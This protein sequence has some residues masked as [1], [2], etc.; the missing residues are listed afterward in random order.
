MPR[1][2]CVATLGALPDAPEKLVV[3]GRPS[4]KHADRVE[5]AVEDSANAKPNHQ[6]LLEV[7]QGLT[8]KNQDLWKAFAGSISFPELKQQQFTATASALGLSLSQVQTLLAIV[9]PVSACPSRAK[10]GRWLATWSARAG[11]L[12]RVLDRQ[13]QKLVVCMWRKMESL[14]EK[15]EAADREVARCRR[16]WVVASKACR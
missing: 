12:L 7:N 15:A 5:Q 16:Q 11:E 4:I 6:E 10:L 14:W 8:Q 13:C 9:V 2:Y 1:P 3:A